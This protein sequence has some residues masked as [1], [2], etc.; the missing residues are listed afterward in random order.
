MISNE[1]YPPFD[2]FD[3]LDMSVK[4]IF[5]SKLTI[6]SFAILYAPSRHFVFDQCWKIAHFKIANKL[7]ST[8]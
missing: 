3:D 5:S 1:K 7:N 2:K 8:A 6:D 4:N